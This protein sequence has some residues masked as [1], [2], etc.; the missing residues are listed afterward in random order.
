M[1]SLSAADRIW[2]GVGLAGQTVFGARFFVQW[3]RSE[4]A[5]RSL[6]PVVFWYLSLA[7]GVLLLLYALHR[8]D[9]VFTL[10][11]AAGL[12]IYARNLYLI[13][14][15]LAAGPSLPDGSRPA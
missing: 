8:R 10:G 1:E 5:G 13:R 12:A 2:L 11:Q 7:G 14:R 4:R 3:L 15:P 6:V 9:L